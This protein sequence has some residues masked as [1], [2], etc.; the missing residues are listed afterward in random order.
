[1]VYHSGI[2]YVVVYRTFGHITESL[3]GNYTLP[4]MVKIR[5]GK[6]A[7]NIIFERRLNNEIARR[8]T[9]TKQ[10]NCTA[11][12]TI[13]GLRILIQKRAPR[14][15]A[16]ENKRQTTDID[17]IKVRQIKLYGKERLTSGRQGRRMYL[18]LVIKKEEEQGVV[19]QGGS[20]G[21][22]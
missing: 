13:R 8:A 16:I 5:G 20:C 1:M 6:A 17:P 18:S 10:R 12:Q 2:S 19:L 21:V 11:L 4:Y 7:R 9:R 15:L 3:I 14:F 22:Q